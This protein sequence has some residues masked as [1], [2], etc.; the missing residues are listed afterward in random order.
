MMKTK[1]IIEKKMFCVTLIFSQSLRKIII[2][3]KEERIKMFQIR[4][5]VHFQGI[6][7]SS[8][9]QHT[10]KIVQEKTQGLRRKWGRGTKFKNPF[11]DI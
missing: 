7:N 11:N 8:V 10:S 9:A 6:A 3:I 4:T 1:N 2:K 5:T